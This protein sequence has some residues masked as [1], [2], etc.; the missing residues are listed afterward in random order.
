MPKTLPAVDVS[1]PICCAPVSAAPMSDD[2]ALELALRLKA[3]ADPTRVKLMSILLTTT[4]GAV[5][6]CDLAIG[7]GLGE[8]TVSHHLAQL[9]KAG[10]VESE[11]RG[12]NVHHRAR[13]EALDALRVVLDPNCC[14]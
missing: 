9:R 8:S 11:R 14:R 7:V 5:C 4:D 10:M 1:G 13:G 2:A 3:L 12:M 6:T